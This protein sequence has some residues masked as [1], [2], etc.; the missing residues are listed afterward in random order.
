MQLNPNLHSQPRRLQF[1]LRNTL[2]AMTVIVVLLAFPVNRAR[3]QHRIVDLVGSR[4]GHLTFDF[5]SR[6]ATEPSAPLWMRRILGDEYFRTLVGVAFGSETNN[7][8][9]TDE[10]LREISTLRSLTLIFLR[11]CENIS[12]AGI[13]SLANL[14]NLKD[15]DLTGTA[16]TDISVAALN[17]LRQLER[18]SFG[19]TQVTDAGIEQLTRLNK[20]QG[21]CL[22][23]TQ[24]TNKGLQEALP[25]MP[26]LDYLVLADTPNITGEIL[27]TVAK[28]KKLSSLSLDDESR[29][30]AQPLEDADFVHLHG[31]S[32][33][34]GLAINGSNIT[35]DGLAEL[36]R[37]L[38]QL[39]SLSVSKTNITDKGLEEL[40][41]LGNI[42]S[43]FLEGLRITDNGL[44]SLQKLPKL[45]FLIV[46]GPQIT[47]V[48][49]GHL[50]QL[51][52]LRCLAICGTR[53]TD[54][55]LGQLTAIS[56]LTQLSLSRNQIGDA[57]VQQLLPLTGLTNLVLNDTLISD[58]SFDYLQNLQ[59]L[60][61]VNIHGCKLTE[62]RIQQFMTDS[63]DIKVDRTRPE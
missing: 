10:D 19:S 3:K 18:L 42:G 20:L 22:N 62:E 40:T 56:S 8:S 38:P 61:K 41:S 49:I 17:N 11:N 5:H 1:R 13:A 35:D 58:S 51:K 37:Q 60:K 29:R 57:G 28:L 36:I 24:V 14:S 52:S 6:G 23:G 34:K 47:D 2:V 33:L 16:T 4:G 45:T 50:S 55:G 46:G 12:D 31:L 30:R 39:R 44:K 53:V 32:N 48:G 26:D 9:L 21:L 7:H 43:L 27:Q 63:P 15:L 59:Q 54:N 25:S